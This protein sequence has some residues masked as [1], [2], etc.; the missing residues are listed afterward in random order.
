MRLVRAR[1][2]GRQAFYSLDDLHIVQLL[3]LAVTHVQ[4]DSG[5]RVRAELLASKD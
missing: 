1:R 5:P 4:E 2:S 3:R